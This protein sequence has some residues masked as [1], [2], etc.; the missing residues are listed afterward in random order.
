MQPE[1]IDGA[2][3]SNS[4]QRG[5]GPF[6]KEINVTGHKKTPHGFRLKLFLKKQFEIRRKIFLPK[7]LVHAAVALLV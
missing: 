1:R 2:V 3:D 4:K 6:R 7:R 5:F